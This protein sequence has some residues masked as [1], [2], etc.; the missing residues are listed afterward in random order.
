MTKDKV[1]SRIKHLSYSN[2]TLYFDIY[3]S[4][5]RLHYTNCPIELYYI[6]DDTSEYLLW[7]FTYSTKS[8]KIYK[9]KPFKDGY[10]K[11]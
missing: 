9:L 4:P 1:I 2:D 5:K 7:K 3:D 10:S 11:I 6:M 8:H